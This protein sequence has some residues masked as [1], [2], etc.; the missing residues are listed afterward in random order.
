MVG[1]VQLEIFKVIFCGQKK[2]SGFNHCA[3]KD[4]KNC[5]VCKIR[6]LLFHN[7]KIARVFL[8]IRVVEI[9]AIEVRSIR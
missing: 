7:L 3:R 8:P 9:D 5:K 1:W 4:C 2:R 6:P